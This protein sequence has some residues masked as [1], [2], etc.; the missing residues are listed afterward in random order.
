MNIFKNFYKFSH[1]IL[2]KLFSLFSKGLALFDVSEY[3]LFY[4][5]IWKHT[6]LNLKLSN[7][8][9]DF[10]IFIMF[11]IFAT[12][13]FVPIHILYSLKMIFE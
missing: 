13:C 4:I 5:I 7:I 6:D 8:S 12:K 11:T 3:S 1:F 9:I 10:I 2:I